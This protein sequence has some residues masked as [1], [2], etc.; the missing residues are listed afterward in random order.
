MAD[1]FQMVNLGGSNSPR[2]LLGQ[3]HQ[4]WGAQAA[5]TIPI[6]ALFFFG[7]VG[8]MG[9]LVARTHLVGGLEQDFI[10]PNS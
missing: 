7:L 8:L 9:Y 5:R 4:C 3:R 2:S 10:F 1:P 6:P